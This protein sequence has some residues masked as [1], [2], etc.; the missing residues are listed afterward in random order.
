MKIKI[1]IRISAVLICVHLLGH[2]VGHLSWDKPDDSRMVEVISSMKGYSA[3]FMG[4][5]KSMADYYHGYSLMMF[6]LFAM[7]IVLLWIL[8]NHATTN[9]KLVKQLLYPIGIIYVCF[10]IIEVIYFFPFAAIVSLLAGI[11]VLLAIFIT[12][13][14][15]AI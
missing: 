1:L 8:S 15:N 2:C 11:F 7:S 6:G 4:A 3:E 14:N 5:T 13:K 10:G 9:Q 12:R